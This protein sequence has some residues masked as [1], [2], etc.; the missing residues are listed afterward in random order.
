MRMLGKLFGF[1]ILLVLVMPLMLGG[2]YFWWD[3]KSRAEDWATSN[4]RLDRLRSVAAF[5]VDQYPAD[6]RDQLAADAYLGNGTPA[7]LT[8]NLQSRL[9]E[10]AVQRGVEIVQASELKFDTPTGLFSKLGIRLEMS[11]PASGIYDVLQQIEKSKPWLFIDNLQIRSGFADASQQAVEPPMFVGMDVW[12]VTA[13][14]ED[15]TKQP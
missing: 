6:S 1:L 15:G 7:I 13:S 10:F 4:E 3:I 9:R 14:A 5:D 12:G 11:G 2:L 8:A